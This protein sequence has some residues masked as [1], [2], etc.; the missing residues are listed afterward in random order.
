MSGSQDPGQAFSDPYEVG[1]IVSN[2]STYQPT[3]MDRKINSSNLSSYLKL[4]KIKRS[5]S[6]DDGSIFKDGEEPRKLSEPTE[7]NRQAPPLRR[8][9]KFSFSST[10]RKLSLMSEQG[11]QIMVD[12]GNAIRSGSVQF[13]QQVLENNGCEILNKPEIQFETYFRR[14]PQTP[15]KYPRKTNDFGTVAVAIGCCGRLPGRLCNAPPR[16]VLRA[17]F[18]SLKN[19]EMISARAAD[20]EF[21]LGPTRP[22][23]NVP[24]HMVLACLIGVLSLLTNRTALYSA[25]RPH[26]CRI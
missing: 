4:N 24:K 20:T 8:K 17:A 25:R 19:F 26:G 5:L 10:P 18:Q 9:S 23:P 15:M 13:V 21:L 22:V 14:I 7:N 16:G 1:L 2:A 6:L 3:I 12:L 11:D